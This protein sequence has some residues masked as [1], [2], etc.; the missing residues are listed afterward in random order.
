MS[1]YL[2]NYMSRINASGN[3]IGESQFNSSASFIEST[4]ADS[5][6]YKVVKCNGQ[7]LEIRLMDINS[8][9]RSSAIQLVQ[10]SLKFILLKPNVSLNI[11]DMIV[12]EDSTWMVTDYTGENLL[13]PKAKIE[14][15]NYLLK[16][17]TGE[18]KVLVGHDNL[19][20]PQYNITPTYADVNCI[21]R[22]SIA[23]VSLNQNINLPNDNLYISM[24]YDDN[25]KLIKEND[26]F[27]IYNKQYKVTGT[28]FTAIHYGKGVITFLTERV[29]N[30][31]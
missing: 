5:P 23:G 9:T 26:M 14:I 3:T 27:D 6:F 13:Y 11:G 12:M 10:Y 18:T 20:R 31:K 1:D 4:F 19:K 25:A 2:L 17:K 16:V 7:D 22:N 29:V 28:D 30:T 21:I 8:V 24:K 15:C